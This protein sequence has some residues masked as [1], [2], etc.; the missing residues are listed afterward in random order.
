MAAQLPYIGRDAELAQIGALIHGSD[1]LRVVCIEASGGI[2]KT[3]LLQEIYKLYANK[4]A[5]LFVADII[6]F[7]DRALRDSENLSFKMSTRIGLNY[8]G[9]YL[10]A[11]QAYHK[12]EMAGVNLERLTK[13]RLK[14]IKAWNSDFNKFSANRRVLYL[15]DT[16]EA[17]KDGDGL[18]YLTTILS[19]KLINNAVFL[20]AGRNTNEIYRALQP[21]LAADIQLLNLLHLDEKASELYLQEKQSLLNFNFN[22]PELTQ[23]LGFISEGRPILLELAAEC[24]AI[25]NPPKWLVESSLKDLLALS[26]SE[27]QKRKDE[28]ERQL[29]L[30]IVQTRKPIDALILT[31]SHV[32]PLD[33]EMIKKILDIS[34]AEAKKL[35]KVALSC[36]FI[37]TLPEQRISLHDEMRRMIVAYV[38]PEVDPDNI[39]KREESQLAAEYF[40]EE[41]EKLQKEIEKLEI[42]DQSDLKIF[43]QLEEL[44]SKHEAFS[45]QEL[46]YTLFADVEKGFSLYK[47]IVDKAYKSR[48]IRIVQQFQKT[49]EPFVSK[50]TL[51]HG[52]WVKIFHG[53]L[54]NVMGQAHEAKKLFDEL[55]SQI[56][57][58]FDPSSDAF[59]SI[60]SEI[61]NA[62]AT[63]ESKLGQLDPALK[64]QLE[65]LKICEQLNNKEDIALVANQIG[66]IHQQRGELSEATKYLDYALDVAV[67]Q[68]DEP[69][70]DLVAGILDHMATVYALKGEYSEAE[71]CS[72]RAIEIWKLRNSSKYVARG[73]ITLAI[74][75]R[76]QD[77]YDQAIEQFQQVINRL[78]EPEESE[79]LIRAYFNMGLTQWLQAMAEKNKDKTARARNF[80]DK[81]RELAEQYGY[82]SYLPGILHQSSGVYWLLGEKEEGRKLNDKAYELSKEFHDIRYAIDSLVGKAELDFSAGKRLDDSEAKQYLDRIPGYARE[83]KEHYEDKNYNFPLFYGRM[84]RYEAE[85]AFRR[86]EY[87]LALDKF[88]EGLIL[89]NDHGGFGR[90]SIARE[91]ENLAQYLAD[92]PSKAISEQWL[93]Y[94]RNYWANLSDKEKH[95]SL[96]RWC[97]DKI[98]QAKLG[99]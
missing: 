19:S 46:E 78:Q 14:I 50:M 10:A 91:L 60:V 23:K 69:N 87:Q 80:F 52:Y 11:I 89:I 79:Q 18:D 51:Q 24:Y 92:L 9:D 16:I 94:L 43:L 63:S 97:D 49:I 4:N 33:V 45:L 13:E 88:A 48:Q 20:M 44:I 57:T 86:K 96:V 54:F 93:F 73:E 27:L 37:K 61:Y 21:A 22:A 47:N 36:T 66:Y 98:L 5:K 64:H 1:K 25:E 7:D 32:Y 15:F 31:M 12:L 71:K 70:F 53:K 85:V 74:V 41:I 38:Q 35:F 65:C 42:Q 99:I 39:R 68:T 3:R 8:F 81:S 90:L 6:D 75:Y 76:E 67:R 82:L 59:L 2:G 58:D 55:L 77:K 83:L 30:D 95:T 62:I 26:V 34:E 17:L 40:K 29:V 56:K 84:R 28:F 72:R